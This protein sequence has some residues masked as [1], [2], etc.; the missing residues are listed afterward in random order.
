MDVILSKNDRY[1]GKYIHARGTGAYSKGR[2]S[3]FQ[4]INAGQITEIGAG[5]LA[6]KTPCAGI[7]FS[8][9]LIEKIFCF[10]I[11]GHRNQAPVK[12]PQPGFLR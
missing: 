12:R 5:W 8:C 3:F 1:S 4:M 10:I 6:E 2:I 9:G 11:P 7:V